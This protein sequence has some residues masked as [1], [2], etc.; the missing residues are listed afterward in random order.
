MGLTFF[1]GGRPEKSQ[2]DM[3]FHVDMGQSVSICTDPYRHGSSY[4]SDFFLRGS[5]GK[6]KS[7]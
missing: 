6:K 5:A 3:N 4:H 1:E 7:E 2:N